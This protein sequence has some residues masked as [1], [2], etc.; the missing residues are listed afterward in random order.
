MKFYSLVLS[1][2][3]IL[4]FICQMVFP[5]FTDALVLNNKSFEQPWRFVTAIFLHSSLT[6]LLFNL[7]ALV[8]FGLILEKLTS[9]NK[10]LIVFF[11]SGIAANLIA[12]NFYQSSLGASGAIF[13]VIGAVTLI[14]PFIFVWAFGLPMPIIVATFLW[15]G[16]NLIETFIPSDIGTI[17]HLSGLFFGLVFGFIFKKS[18]KV[19]RTPQVKISEDYFRRW[20]N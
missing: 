14:R 12:V 13:G 7:F 6:H 1:G 2:I 19:K 8:L 10:F 9:S 18:V 17:A 16:G 3:I 4:F 20:K 15:I 11:V 5:G